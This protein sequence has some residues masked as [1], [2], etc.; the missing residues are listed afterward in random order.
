MAP[1]AGTGVSTRS[2]LVDAGGAPG[3]D[4]RGGVMGTAE[5]KG[6]ATQTCGPEGK[7]DSGICWYCGSPGASCAETCKSHGGVSSQAPSHVGTPAQGGSVAECAR[8]LGLFGVTGPL[9]SLSRRDGAGVG[10][11]MFSVSGADVIFWLTSPDYRDT[12][13]LSGARILCGCSQ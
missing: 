6:D 3:D 13:G 8:L 1:D 4:A 7:L 5:T 11:H 2:A 10:C 9:L 12:A